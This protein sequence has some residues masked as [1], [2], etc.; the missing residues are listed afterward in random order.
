MSGDVNGSA[1]FLFVMLADFII[2]LRKQVNKSN[3]ILILIQSKLKQIQRI[4]L[5]KILPTQHPVVD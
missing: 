3:G 2:K 1:T 5:N 4:D